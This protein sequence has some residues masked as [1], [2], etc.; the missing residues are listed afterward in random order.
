M[1]G[2]H[3]PGG[4]GCQGRDHAERAAGGGDRADRAV[5]V[6]ERRGHRVVRP[7]PVRGRRPGP[8][9][10]AVPRRPISAQGPLHKLCRPDPVQRQRGFERGG[11][12]RR[13][14]HDTSRPVQGGRAGHRR[15][16]EHPGDGQP[17]DHTA[18]GLG[19]D[20]QPVGAGAYAGRVQWWRRRRGG[21]RDGSIRKRLGRGWEHPHPGVVLRAPGTQAEPGRITVGP[22]RAEVGLGSNYASAARCET[23]RGCSMRCAVPVSATP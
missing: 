4:A 23:Q 8:A 3:G 11:Q 13:C 12:D 19:A 7:R 20:A 18:A 9:R 17:A 10:R 6:A 21:R 15:A 5:E 2:C 16:D 22:A 1:D 14:R